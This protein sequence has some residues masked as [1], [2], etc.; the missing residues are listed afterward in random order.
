MKKSALRAGLCWSVVSTHLFAIFFA[1]F[2]VGRQNFDE[3]LDVILIMTPLT[4]AYLMIIVQYFMGEADD[5]DD[6]VL[7]RP[8]A[9]QLVIVL[10]LAFGAALI[11]V[12]V[13]NWAGQL[14]LEPLKRSVGVI[15]TVLGV[16]VSI[17]IKRLFGSEATAPAPAPAT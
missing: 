3:A 12:L 7:M 5:R 8:I 13:M 10:T 1:A 11:G 15:E 4:G 16:Y 14:G 2:A 6:L 9:G 17:F